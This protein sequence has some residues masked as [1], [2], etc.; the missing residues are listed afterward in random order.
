MS[1]NSALVALTCSILL[2][3]LLPC[4]GQCHLK[5][6][7]CP[8]GLPGDPALL[9]DLNLCTATAGL[10][11]FDMSFPVGHLGSETERFWKKVKIEENGCWV[12]Q[13]QVAPD[14]YGKFSLAASTGRKGSVG[15]H[16][17]SYEHCIGPV[18]E[19][20][21]LDHLCRN[22]ACVNPL[23]LEPVTGKMNKLRGVSFSAINAQKTAC[24][25]GHPFTPENTAFYKGKRICKTCKA[26][27]YKN[28]YDRKKADAS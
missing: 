11:D 16:V 15:A 8:A 18:P 27:H 13:A 28:W 25:K 23:H 12:W 9:H 26:A 2:S 1:A 10:E 4:K 19:K 17:W 7:P 21:Q 24:D 3:T 22:R 14:G 20:L 6:F 5:L